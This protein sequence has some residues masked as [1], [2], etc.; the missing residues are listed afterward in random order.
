MGR[1]QGWN[2]TTPTGV[3][4]GYDAADVDGERVWFCCPGCKTKY[5]AQSAGA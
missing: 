2:F 4:T 3:T 1:L 5:A